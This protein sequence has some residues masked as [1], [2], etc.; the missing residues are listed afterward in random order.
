MSRVSIPE[1]P[2]REEE[3]QEYLA[4][5]G[6]IEILNDLTASLVFHRPEN[7]KLF[8]LDE[9]KKLHR[10][11]LRGEVTAPSL[12]LHSNAEAIFRTLDR[13]GRGYITPQQYTETLTQLGVRNF[14]Q[15]DAVDQRK[16]TLE[17][18]LAQ[19]HFRD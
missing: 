3:A 8:L 1:R 11:R 18:F 12:L 4:K 16:V 10:A 9:V 7:P 15:F 6:I 17:M 13:T 19:F 5:H 14:E 2:T